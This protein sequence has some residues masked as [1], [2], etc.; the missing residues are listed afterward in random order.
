MDLYIGLDVSLASTAICVVSSH[1]KVIRET[2]AA[3][4]PEELE[5]ALRSL[6]GSVVGSVWRPGRC[7]NGSIGTSP[8]PGSIRF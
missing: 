6:S 1:G 4:E 3:S 8:T 2:I 7:H 5:R